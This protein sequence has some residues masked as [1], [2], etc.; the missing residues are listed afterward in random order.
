MVSVPNKNKNLLNIQQLYWVNDF[1]KLLIQIYRVYHINLKEF[2]HRMRKNSK[3]NN[4]K[5]VDNFPTRS[6]K[7]F[8]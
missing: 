4:V 5:I 2:K 3:T 8:F 7:N 1:Q 6:R